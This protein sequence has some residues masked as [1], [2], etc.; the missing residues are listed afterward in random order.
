MIEAR[1][2]ARDVDEAVERASACWPALKGARIFLT[3]GT[4]FFGAWLLETLLRANERHG[5]GVRAVLLARDPEGFAARLPRLARHPSVDVLKGDVRAFAAPRGGFSHVVHAAAPINVGP[6]A[7]EAVE[8][9]RDGTRRVLELARAAGAREVLYV[10]SGSVYGPRAEPMSEE[11]PL[12][13]ASPY[14]EGKVLAEELSAAAG[15]R[16]ARAFSFVGPY[17]PLD[18]HNALACFMSDGLAGRPVRLTGDACAVRSYLYGADL[19]VWLWTILLRGAPGRAYNVGSEAAVTIGELAA[20]VAAHFGVA[21]D[22]SPSGKTAGLYVPSTRR[23]REE[24]GLAETVG[25]DE[26]IARMA[27]ACR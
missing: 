25:L 16:I 24:L 20:K 3:G 10:S 9:S 1:P 4:R 14:A 22:S 7:R 15:A 12:A 13:P 17:L 11:H 21:V 27:A 26:A 6:D 2:L 23:A 19:A 18:R 8:I 5:L